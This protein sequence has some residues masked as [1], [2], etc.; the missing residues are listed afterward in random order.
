MSSNS[1]SSDSVSDA[2]VSL[3]SLRGGAPRLSVVE[4]DFR[5]IHLR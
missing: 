5:E 2:E 1:D 4:E 3:Q